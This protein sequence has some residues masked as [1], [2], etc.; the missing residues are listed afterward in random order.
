[1]GS[2][3][4]QVL[5]CLSSVGIVGGFFWILSLFL[6]LGLSTPCAGTGIPHAFT[7]TICTKENKKIYP[8]L[9]K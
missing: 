6:L 1:M 7:E 4:V 5:L 8:L 9:D 3:A 2:I